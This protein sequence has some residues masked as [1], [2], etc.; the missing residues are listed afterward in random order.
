MG[1]FLSKVRAV[2]EAA[3]KA[4][5]DAASALSASIARAARAVARFFSALFRAAASAA[6]SVFEALKR[7][8]AACAAF[9]NTK[10]GK[11]AAA[12]AVAVAAGLCLGLCFVPAAA[13][14]AGAMMLAPGSGGLIMIPRSVFVANAALYFSVLRSAGPAAAAA[15]VVAMAV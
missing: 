14:G 15:S 5:C 7:A 2:A 9:F 10:K 11:V 6:A 13:G 12:V 3:V 1:G 4:V 8:A